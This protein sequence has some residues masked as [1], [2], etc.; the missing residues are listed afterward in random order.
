MTRTSLILSIRRSLIM[1]CLYSFQ[2][3][4]VFTGWLN[5]H[6]MPNMFNKC[7]SMRN[8]AAS[9]RVLCSSKSFSRCLSNVHAALN[10]GSSNISIAFKFSKEVAPVTCNRWDFLYFSYITEYIL[11]TTL[12]L[13]R[14]LGIHFVSFQWNA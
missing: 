7:R 9:V 3:C 5:K 10:V 4:S 14:I 2:R 6:L 12:L 11:A 1:L 8:I 13:T